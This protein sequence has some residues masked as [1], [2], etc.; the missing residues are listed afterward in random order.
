MKSSISKIMKTI[1]AIMISIS[2][3]T[4]NKVA[5]MRAEE[6]EQQTKPLSGRTI[7]ILGDSISTY[8]GVSDAEPITDEGVEHR[9]GEPY[10]GPVGEDVHCTDYQLED[11][12]WYQAAEETGAEILMVNSGNSTGVYI[13][14]YP[15][16]ADWDAYLKDMRGYLTR[17]NHLGKDGKSPDIIALYLGSAEAGG[18]AVSNY[19]SVSDVNFDELITKSGDGY[20]YNEPTNLA[21][22]YCIMMHKIKTNY[23]QAEIYCFKVIPN[24]GGTAATGTT[25]MER[26]NAF[27]KL[28]DE[29][30]AYFH[31]ITVDLPAEFN[32]DSNGDGTISESE[33]NAYKEF[34]FE[35]P[36]PTDIGFDKIT[37]AFLDQV[38]AKSRYIVEVESKAG[39]NENVETEVNATEQD[40]KIVI[41]RSAED[42]VTDSGMI[43]DYESTQT[44]N[45][46]NT[47]TFEDHYTSQNDIDTYEAEGGKESSNSFVAP[48]VEVG[49]IIDENA[50]EAAEV[51]GSKEGIIKETGDKKESPE[52]G[53]YDYRRTSIV[54]QGRAKLLTTAMN[55]T[56]AHSTA[57]QEDMEYV[58]SEVRPVQNVTRSSNGNDLIYGVAEEEAPENPEIADGYNYLYYGSDQ[59]SR[60][61]SAYCYNTIQDSMPAEEPVYSDDNHTLYV[62]VGHNNFSKLKV[63]KLYFEEGAVDTPAGTPAKWDTIQQFKLIDRNKK[64]LTAYCADRSTSAER[65]FSYNIENLE[66]A[67]Y[68]SEEEAKKIRS[69]AYNGYWGDE[70]FGSLALLKEKLGSTDSGFTA[71]EIEKITDGIAMTATQFAIWHFSNIMENI[72]FVNAYVTDKVAS[73][74]RNGVPAPEE[75]AE[76]IFK[77]YFY[78]INLEPTAIAEEDR[79][80]GNTIINEKNFLDSISFKI[81]DKPADEANNKDSDTTNDVYTVDFSFKLKVKPSDRDDL[82]LTIYDAD[83]NEIA[84]G[85]IAGTQGQ[86]ESQVTLDENGTYTLSNVRMQEGDD[87]LSFALTGVQILENDV[88]LLTSEV[89]M[90]GDEEERSQPMVTVAQGSRS[91]NVV[92]D[93]EFQLEVDDEEQ[94]EEHIWRTEKEVPQKTEI[95]VIK[96]WADDNNKYNNRPEFITVH[97]LADGKEL[98]EAKLTAENEWK[99]TF[100]DLDK[101]NSDEKE[102]VYTIEEDTDSLFESKIDGFKVINTE[103]RTSISVEKK[104]DDGDDKNKN[105]PEAITVHLFAN[106]TEIA[107]AQLTAENEW[108]FEFTN[109]PIYQDRKE[110]KYTV[111]EDEVAGYVTNVEGLKIINTEKKTNIS[112]E[113]EWADEN[114]KNNNRPEAITVHLLADGTEVASTRLTAEN[115]WKY[116]FTDLP[117]YQNGKEIKYSVTEDEVDG[118]VTVIEGFKI[119]NTENKINIPVTKTWRNDEENNR[120]DSITV[121]LFADGTEIASA[122]L[123]KDNGYKYEFTDL[124]EYSNGKKITYEITEDPVEGYETTIDGFTITNTRT[125]DT[126]DNT[127]ILLWALILFGSL[128]AII[129]I[130]LLSKSISSRKK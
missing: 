2:C 124:N 97:L 23:P 103:K 56:S 82:K 94:L 66:D 40:G 117:M 44:A 77:L 73:I 38:Y 30:S 14:N 88:Y 101:Y 41:T 18:L 75:N 6:T 21:E 106:E 108:K 114:N 17:P 98:E 54:K 89:R 62:G 99:Y 67:T 58:Y 26:V 13:A 50:T 57:H 31:A 84:V 29:V 61:W 59:F 11:M 69:I 87:S 45:K 91:V 19:G 96:E 111:T 39:L 47:Q 81:I 4:A 7:S 118:Y 33:W 116:E 34:F 115:E 5:V 32:I 85:R 112:I 127:N 24:S 109:L 79:N 105:R 55:I 28:V 90:N 20:S 80:T 52:D 102:I 48:G 119:V 78:L 71:E 49:L 74:T 8:F 64:V 121:H 120:P 43:V 51:A 110:I 100:T 83:G 12:W 42:Y 65:G 95:E 46:D 92:M 68:Y 70:N 10:Y 126:G 122:E 113:K 129:V 25:R 63:F 16:D 22:A 9:I 35:G 27:N 72:E 53:I 86:G 3:V 123:T 130:L 1:L 93:V 36:H 15:A 104:W 76:L 125:V 37:K 107:E 128:F 60:F